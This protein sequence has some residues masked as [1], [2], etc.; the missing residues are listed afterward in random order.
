M[1][2]AVD[3]MIYVSQADAEDM[4]RRLARE[5]G[6]FAGISA[7]GACWVALQ[8]ARGRERDHR[9]HRLR[10]RRPLP[11]D[12]VF[13]LSAGR[14]AM[15]HEFRF[16]PHCASE[17]APISADGTAVPRSAA[18]RRLRL[19]TGTIRRRSS[20]RSSSAP[21]ATASCCSPATR[22]GEGRMFGLITG[23]MELASR[24]RRASRA[25][26]R[27]TALTVDALSI[28]G[29][30]DF[31][32][33]NQV[34]IAYHARRAATSCFRRNWPSTGCS[35]RT[36]VAG[37]PARDM[38]SPTGC[39]RAATSRSGSNCRRAPDPESVALHGIDPTMTD[40][41]EKSMPA[42]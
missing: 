4:A 17:L 27:R 32:R 6:I 35:A 9:V 20:P 38:R 33:M 34:I 39:A 2:S 12:R 23:F 7:A 42:A 16:C 18:L 21:T 19:R 36:C 8:V 3:E 28:I 15:R 13:P 5:E 26:W 40:A 24:R 10:P 14:S 11:V 1:P 30:Y 31:Q 41:P 29:V 37:A 25:R 22:P